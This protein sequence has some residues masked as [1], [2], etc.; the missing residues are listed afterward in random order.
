MRSRCGLGAPLLPGPS[1][2]ATDFPTTACR[3]ARA[4]EL[5]IDH[6]Q[7]Q[8]EARVEPSAVKAFVG[9]IEL[10]NQTPELILSA[11]K[12]LTEQPELTKKVTLK[13]SMV[14]GEC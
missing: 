2:G 10:R 8:L 9:M 12:R 6:V 13:F 4:L 11:Y 14:L 1:F 7:A 3:Q 5:S